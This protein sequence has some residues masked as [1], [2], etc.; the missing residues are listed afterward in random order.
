MIPERAS[1]GGRAPRV[2]VIDDLGGDQRGD[3]FSVPTEYLE[4]VGAPG[5]MHVASIRP[6]HVRGNHFHVERHELILVLPHEAWSLHWDSGA[7]TAVSTREFHGPGAV[8]IAIPP[9]A[10]HAI[11]NDG[12]ALLWLIAAT[13]G[14]YDPASPDAHR[15]E[16]VRS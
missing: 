14:R 12:Q 4:F 11:R 10:A 13:D 7:D 6:G 1:T 8:A 9:S 15:R 16:V 5:D 3:S 2:V